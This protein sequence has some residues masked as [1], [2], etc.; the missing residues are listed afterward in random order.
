MRKLPL[1]AFLSVVFAGCE[2]PIAPLADPITQVGDES[3]L[4]GDPE[5]ARRGARPVHRAFPR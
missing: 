1:A 3:K 5:R 4:Y 2:T